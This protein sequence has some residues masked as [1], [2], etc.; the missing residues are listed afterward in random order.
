[1][2]LKQKLLVAT[3]LIW[4]ALFWSCDAINPEDGELTDYTCEGCHTNRSALT[5]IIETLHLEPHEEGEEAP[6]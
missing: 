5:H 3:L 1:M 2:R 4:S 6:G